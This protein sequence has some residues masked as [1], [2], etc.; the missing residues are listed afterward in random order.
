MLK[1]SLANQIVEAKEALEL[2]LQNEA[3][4]EPDYVE[5]AI[6]EVSLAQERLNILYE[7]AKMI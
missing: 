7:K 1:E 2:A 5:F 4:A 6:R 3:F